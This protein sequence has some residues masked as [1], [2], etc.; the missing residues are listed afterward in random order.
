MK[1]PK[2]MQRRGPSFLL[3][4]FQLI[5]SVELKENRHETTCSCIEIHPWQSNV[6]LF[7]DLVREP[8]AK[9]SR[10]S[11][12]LIGRKWRLR[13]NSSSLLVKR[14]ILTIVLTGVCSTIGLYMGVFTHFLEKDYY[15]EFSYPMEGNLQPLVK[16][17]ISGNK[18]PIKPINVFNYSYLKLCQDKCS[19]N[20]SLKLLLVVKSALNHFEQRQAIRETWGNK[21]HI[22]DVEVLCVF[23]LGTGIDPAIQTKLDDEDRFHGDIVQADFHDD[24]RNNTLKTMSGFKWA[25]EQCPSAR[26]IVFSDDDMYVST[27]NLFRFIRNPSN[28]PEEEFQPIVKDIE[29]RERSLKEQPALVAEG[30]GEE[31]NEIGNLNEQSK[32]YAGYVF[33]SPPQRHRSSKWYVSLNEY[34]YHLWPPY[35]T[36]GAYVVSRAALLDLHYGSFY[37]KYFEFDDIF[38]ALVALKIN[39][40]PV[41]CS[42]FYFWKKSYSQHGYRDVI[43]SHGYSNPDE[44]RTVWNEQKSAGNA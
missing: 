8:L 40:E 15:T 34:P 9:K 20:T 28:Y 3:Q 42:E 43:A 30:F 37:T 41:H 39:I 18:P 5:A 38:L 6:M 25:V 12:I 16:E 7:Y 2:Q 17:L 26:Y 19:S 1:C 13:R 11:M 27:K 32:L 24:Y 33:H 36:A 35:V 4:A 31:L 44:L 14:V 23:L 21:L 10:L 22:S 29:H